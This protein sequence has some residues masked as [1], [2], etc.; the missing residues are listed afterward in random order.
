MLKVINII[1][2]RCVIFLQCVIVS[3]IN[4]FPAFIV[5]FLHP[6][7]NNRSR[8]YCIPF[9]KTRTI[10]QTSCSSTKLTAHYFLHSHSTCCH[11]AMNGYLPGDPYQWQSLHPSA[12]QSMVPLGLPSQQIACEPSHCLYTKGKENSW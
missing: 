10:Q 2:L 4:R 6:L 5:C 9:D 7:E 8:F 1:Y 11:N 12:V 3:R